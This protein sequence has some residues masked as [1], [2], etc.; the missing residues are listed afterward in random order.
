MLVWIFWI[1]IMLAVLSGWVAVI[2]LA[3]ALWGT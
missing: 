1:S 3:T 2:L